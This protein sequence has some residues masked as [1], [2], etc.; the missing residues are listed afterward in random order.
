MPGSDDGLLAKL[1]RPLRAGDGGQRSAI[2]SEAPLDALDGARLDVSDGT[3]LTLHYGGTQHEFVVV[4][5]ADGGV[6][7]RPDADTEGER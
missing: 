5:G 6:S 1:R 7:V 3:R 2:G 4:I